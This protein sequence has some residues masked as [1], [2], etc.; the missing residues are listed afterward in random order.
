MSTFYT[1]DRK[2]SGA[3]AVFFPG[4]WSEEGCETTF[5]SNMTS[6]SCNH[7]THFAILLSSKPLDLTPEH[8]LALQTI[9]A[10]GVSISLVAMALTILVFIYLKW[11]QHYAIWL[12][13]AATYYGGQLKLLTNN[14][15]IVL[16]YFFVNMH[17]HPCYSVAQSIDLFTKCET[18][19]T[20]NC[21]WHWALL[22][23]YLWQELSRT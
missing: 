17:T 5:T 14:V 7:L 19:S 12:F 9:S 22:R 21:V 16:L 6:C 3:Q 8:S 1:Y 20:F 18:T 11:V 23:L 15:T 4:K 10:I 2:Q 13:F